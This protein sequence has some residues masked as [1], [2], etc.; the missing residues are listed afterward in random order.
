MQGPDGL[1]DIDDVPERVWECRTLCDCRCDGGLQEIHGGKAPCLERCGSWLPIE[2]KDMCG[3]ACLSVWR[4]SR[5]YEEAGCERCLS[6]RKGHNSNFRN[7]VD[8]ESSDARLPPP[9][10]SGLRGQGR[11]PNWQ[12]LARQAP[13]AS[14][15]MVVAWAVVRGRRLVKVIS[16]LGSTWLCRAG[17][18]I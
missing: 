14:P 11:V 3:R 1:V 9:Q 7:Q 12:Q 13:R 10:S 5:S 15:K 16:A 2:E 17:L 18:T 4:D 6:G 8:L